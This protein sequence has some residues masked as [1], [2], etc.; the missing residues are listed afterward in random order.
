MTSNQTIQRFL[1]YFKAAGMVNVGE[2][3]T[4]DDL[5]QARRFCACLRVGILEEVETSKMYY[6]LR[7]LA[8]RGYLVPKDWTRA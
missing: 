2:I 7:E 3:H 4:Q 8:S 1:A 6:S 5:E